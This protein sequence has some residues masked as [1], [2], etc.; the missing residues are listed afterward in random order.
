M[1]SKSLALMNVLSHI[2]SEV[3]T[4]GK[5]ILCSDY[6]GYKQNNKRASVELLVNEGLSG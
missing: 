5:V 4:L 1:V 6:S 3:G 2:H